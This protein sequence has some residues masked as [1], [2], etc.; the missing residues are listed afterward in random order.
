MGIH[1][2]L[3]TVNLPFGKI[4]SLVVLLAIVTPSSCAQDV[5]GE[6]QNELGSVLQIDSI[7]SDGVLNGIYLSSSGV[8]GRKFP[9]IGYINKKEDGQGL[10][11]AFM[12]HWGDYGSITSW[13]GYYERDKDG[14]LIKTL[15]HLVRPHEDES[16]NALLPIHPLSERDLPLL[17]E[18][19]IT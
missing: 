3:S 14:P 2:L 1:M 11:I 5:I 15:W 9:L 4:L 6:W 16:W 19:K 7:G 17:N 10:A 18:R 12:V 13:S 8:D